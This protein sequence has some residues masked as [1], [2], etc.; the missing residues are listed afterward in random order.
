MRHTKVVGESFTAVPSQREIR[1]PQSASIL[2][3][4]ASR[5]RNGRMKPLPS[6]PTAFP[7]CTL[8]LLG[9]GNH[10]PPRKADRVPLITMGITGMPASVATRKDPR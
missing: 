10:C 8:M 5:R 3:R 9:R 6:A 4:T 7:M 2:A 1:S